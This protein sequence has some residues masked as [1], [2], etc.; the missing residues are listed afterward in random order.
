MVGPHLPG[1]LADYRASEIIEIYPGSE[2]VFEAVVDW[3]I[4]NSDMKKRFYWSEDP[5]TRVQIYYE[6]LGYEFTQGED[7]DGEWL[8]SGFDR[9]GKTIQPIVT[10][11]LVVHSSFCL[12]A[13]DP[14]HVK[15]ILNCYTLVLI[16][17]SQANILDLSV[18]SL[19]NFRNPAPPAELAAISPT[20]TL[21]VFSY[22]RENIL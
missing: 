3:H 20:G 2:K 19:S 22:Y 18:A 8:I 14:V 16:D 17:A 15:P 4:P 1:I 7:R 5:I 11:N 10:I 13:S 12:N 21:I 9:K 6:K